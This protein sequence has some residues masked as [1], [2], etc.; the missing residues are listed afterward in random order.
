MFKRVFVKM[1]FAV[2]GIALLGGCAGQSQA[3]KEAV[4]I[5]MAKSLNYMLLVAL[6]Q[7]YFSNEGLEVTIV[8]YST[9]K[10]VL[11]DGVF[12]GEVDMGVV[13]L[14]PLTFASLERDD[15]KIV[16][17]ISTFFDLYR[18][19]AR[20]DAGISTPADLAGKRVATSKGSSFHYFLHNFLI[21]NKLSEEDI[22]MSFPKAA[23]LPQAL[24][25]G[26]V[27]AF[28]GREPFI[29]EA[30]ALLGD[31]AIVF[32]ELELPAN[33]LN[34]VALDGLVN[35]R[36][37]VVESVLRALLQAEEFIRKNPEKSIKIVAEALEI[38]ESELTE[39][40]PHV[41]LRVSLDQELIMELENIARWAIRTELTE[42]TEEP[43]YL[44]YL[45]VDGLEKVNA[46]I[47]TV[48]K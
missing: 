9:G 2:L 6:E 4:T 32:S 15:F 36:P 22:E 25:D 44:D 13:G 3:P 31:E 46:K 23:E 10:R 34:L 17:S 43:N 40:W 29:S 38:E 18:I 5:G 8:E 41:I 7:G 27:D 47:V 19:V 33:T 12:A 42:Q 16:G 28:S 1:I 21:E 37:E 20:K 39:R 48:I 35:E 14:G 30:Q 24:A 11:Q 26:E 45:Y